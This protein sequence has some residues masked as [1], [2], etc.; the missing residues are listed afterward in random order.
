V[1]FEYPLFNVTNNPMKVRKDV[2]SDN[3]NTQ[4]TKEEKI[5]N[6]MDIAANTPGVKLE[7]D[8]LEEDDEISEELTKIYNLEYDLNENGIN[9]KYE[10]YDEDGNLVEESIHSDVTGKIKSKTEYDEDGN[11]KFKR[12]Y[13]TKKQGKTGNE[14]TT[15]NICD[16]DGNLIATQITTRDKDGNTQSDLV[17][18]PDGE[19]TDSKIYEYDENGEIESETIYSLST[20]E[21]TSNKMLNE[22]I[23]DGEGNIVRAHFVETNENGVICY[24]A[25]ENY[26]SDN[27]IMY[28]ITYVYN[29]ENN[30]LEFIRKSKMY[31]DDITGE[32]IETSERI[33]ASGELQSIRKTKTRTD[34]ITGQIITNEECYDGKGNLSTTAIC[35]EDENGNLMSVLTYN[36][37]GKL[38]DDSAYEYDEDGNLQNVTSISPYGLKDKFI[39]TETK[40][41]DING[42]IINTRSIITDENG[43]TKSDLIYDPDDE[44]IEGSVFDYDEDGNLKYSTKT[45]TNK[46]AGKTTKTEEIFDED[47]NVKYKLITNTKINEITSQM[48]TSE[49]VYGTNGNTIDNPRIY[50][51]KQH[52]ETQGLNSEVDD[53]SQGQIGDCW[54]LSGINSFSYSEIGREIIKNAINETENGYTVELQGLGENVEISTSEL[55]K[56]IESGEYSS[57]DPD[58]ILFELAFEKANFPHT[59]DRNAWQDFSGYSHMTIDGGRFKDVT[60]AI[61]GRQ[62]NLAVNDRYCE[63][64][65]NIGSVLD[66]FEK[67]DSIAAVVSFSPTSYGEGVYITDINGEEYIA[68]DNGGSHAWSLKSVDKNNA[69][70]V[71]PWDSSEEI[72]IPRN[73][74]IKNADHIEY[75]DLADAE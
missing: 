14:I 63:D 7:V 4:L 58:M 10:Q 64:C 37:D 39:K 33:D 24:E 27:K 35:T 46:A 44:L 49:I 65:E 1:A 16:A 55:K 54:L 29:K 47:G 66:K 72:V 38:I 70:I 57:G 2:D 13:T 36:P 31:T 48:T 43:K 8:C 18:N 32:V 41:Y 60:I 19:L 30:E 71:N 50:F 53:S 74:L 59:S 69:T 61:L 42:D 67:S 11:V 5:D 62:T 73:E 75:I 45:K 15:Q 21:I 51:D 34:D 52:L 6:I 40:S 68:T 56:A 26:D 25:E 23:K 9:E 22:L 12:T 28:G 17:Y 3:Q 20:N